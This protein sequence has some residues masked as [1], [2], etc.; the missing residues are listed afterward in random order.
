M[1]EIHTFQ[2]IGTLSDHELW[3]RMKSGDANAYELIYKRFFNV[4]AKYGL[5]IAK[6][7]Q[8]VEDAIQDVFIDIW[9]RREFLTEADNPKF[10]L[11]RAIRNK[12]L[13]NS[14]K[15]PIDKSN[16]IDDFLDYLVT[17]SEEHQIIDK[18]TQ[19]DQIKRIQEAISN[20]SPRQQEV[21]NL[22]FY[23]GLSIDE[24]SALMALSK[25]AVHNLVSRSYAVLRMIIQFFT[26]LPV[27][28]VK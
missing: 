16:D 24:I 11:F 14:Q 26:L 15:D 12:I 17:L 13:R 1:G 25:Q 28:A 20:L 9:R 18:E 10:Y 6:D 7:P 4:M 3:V 19:R 5:K 21:I 22:R 27:Y 2:G 8:L 23:H